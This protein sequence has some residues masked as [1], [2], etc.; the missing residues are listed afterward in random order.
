MLYCT[1]SAQHVGISNDRMNVAYVGISNPLTIVV[2]GCNPKLVNVSTDNGTIADKGSG[3][4]DYTPAKQGKALI[5]LSVKANNGVK[6]IGSKM[7]RIKDIPMPVAKINRPDP[8]Y[9]GDIQ[10]GLAVASTNPDFDLNFKIVSFRI[11]ISRNNAEISSSNNQGNRFDMETQNTLM[12][13]K[14][15]DKI[16]FSEIRCQYPDGRIVKIEDLIVN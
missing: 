5:K 9:G 10:R 4:Y 7:Y 15:G 8:Q 1:S 11:S 12:K 16:M 3:K 14:Q 13:W 2:E 6:E